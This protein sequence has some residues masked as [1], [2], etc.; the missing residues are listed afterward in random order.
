M[1][2]IEEIIDKKKKFIFVPIEVWLS[3]ETQRSMIITCISPLCISAME[4]NWRECWKVSSHRESR[5]LAI[6]VNL[7]WSQNSAILERGERE[8]KKEGEGERKEGK[9]EWVRDRWVMLIEVRDRKNM[10]GS[11]ACL[12]DRMWKQTILWPCWSRRSSIFVDATLISRWYSKRK[13]KK[14]ERSRA[15]LWFDQLF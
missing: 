13:N 9:R 1:F 3:T 11:S 7:E 15:V 4:T 14:L 8:R 12:Y 2:T 10:F 6:H 5:E